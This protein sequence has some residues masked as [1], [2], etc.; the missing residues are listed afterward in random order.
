MMDVKEMIIAS[1]EAVRDMGLS[2][3]L[4]SGDPEGEKWQTAFKQIA[5]VRKRCLDTMENP[6]V[7]I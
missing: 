5:E 3:I 4:W 1:T 2:E 6:R 7:N